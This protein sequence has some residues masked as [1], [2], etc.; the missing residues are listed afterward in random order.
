VWILISRIERGYNL[1]RPILIVLS[2]IYIN[3]SYDGFLPLCVSMF[4]QKPRS[5][6]FILNSTLIE[7][8][9]P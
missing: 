4:P 8:N 1:S 2:K 5:V 7:I 6:I 3:Y 9:G